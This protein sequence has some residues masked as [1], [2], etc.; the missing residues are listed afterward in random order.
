MQVTVTNTVPPQ[1]NLVVF[2]FEGRDSE[3]TADTTFTYK[4]TGGYWLIRYIQNDPTSRSDSIFVEILD[5]VIPQFELNACGSNELYVDIL[6][7]NYDL[8]EIDYGDGSIDTTAVNI[9]PPN[10]SYGAS[11]TRNVTVT[12][13]YST[14]SN[15]CGFSSISFT[16]VNQVVSAQISLMEILDDQSLVIQYNLA[17]NTRTSLEIAINNDTNFQLFKNIN[18]GTSRDTLRNLQLLTATYCFRIASHDACSNFKAYSNTLCSIYTDAAAVNNTVDLTWDTIYPLSFSSTDIF[19]DGTLLNSNT[20]QNL[21]YSDTSVVCNTSYCYSIDIQ[22]NDG[23]ISRSNQVCDNAFSSDTPSTIVDVSSVVTDTEIQWSWLIP[24]NEQVQWYRVLDQNSSLLDTALNNSIST[25]YLDELG[26]CIKLDYVNQCNNTSDLSRLFCP[27]DLERTLNGSGSTSLR[28]EDYTSWVNGVRNY[29]LVIYDQNMNVLDSINLGLDTEY[30]D[31]LPN[32]NN[33][34]NYYKVWAQANDLGPSLSNSKLVKVE[35][36]AIIGI[37]NSFTPNNDNLNDVFAVTGKFIQSVEINII[38]RWGST[39]YQ[40]NGATWDGMSN[41]NKV[42]L[43]N[44]VYH[45]KVKDFAG[46]E[47]I[48]T[49]S[50]LIL[51]D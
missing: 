38:N 41:G 47:L 42:P 5:P 14:A 7:N 21:S 22:H 36:P 28:W 8:Y 15:R 34:V 6:D 37:P 20:T 18:Q 48:R 19:R 9:V 13:L 16:P 25:P 35:R 2:L 10:Y 3:V 24:N 29:S 45:I 44:Y 50:V 17:P 39:I 27:I 31:P 49:G 51:E 11:T 4:S 1:S 32:D 33:Q 26:V 40:V 43:G 46:N 12:G 23:S 30:T